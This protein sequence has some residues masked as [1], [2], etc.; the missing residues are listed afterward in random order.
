M[1]GLTYS[2]AATGA[3]VPQRGSISSY[4]GH[5]WIIEDC[6]IDWSNA[7]GIDIGNECWHHEIIK[8]QPIGHSII[9]R[10]KIYDAGVCGIAGLFASH[11]LIE[12]NLIQGTGWQRM[13]LSWEAAITL[14][15]ENNE[16]KRNLYIKPSGRYL[17]VM[18][19]APQV[20]LDLPTWRKFYGFDMTG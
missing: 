18:Y 17:R 8:D 6:I 20:C 9:R 12:D 13:E 3:P 11:F 15:T 5:H 2:H 14:P 16:V 1:K 10:C 19:P 4:R 7:V